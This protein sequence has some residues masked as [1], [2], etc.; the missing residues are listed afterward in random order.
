MAIQYERIGKRITDMPTAQNYNTE[1]DTDIVGEPFFDATLGTPTTEASPITFNPGSM[2]A[3][4]V[5]TAIE[6]DYELTQLQ[7][8]FIVVS[9]F[10]RIGADYTNGKMAAYK[11]TAVVVPGDDATGNQ[12]LQMSA[13]LNWIGKKTH[14]TYDPSAS[15]DKFTAETAPPA[16][17]EI[18]YKDGDA[19]RS[20][21]ALYYIY[22]DTAVD[23]AGISGM[24]ATRKG[25]AITF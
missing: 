12:S 13:T 21:R 10:K 14:G 20:D 23:I 2:F 3:R 1:G 8:D 18:H 22:D 15:G 17:S 11:R 5:N 25:D 4:F 7:K 16:D 9:V 19:S 24:S 6:R